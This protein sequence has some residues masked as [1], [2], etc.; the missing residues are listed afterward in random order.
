MSEDNFDQFGDILQK[1]TGIFG[2]DTA[3]MNNALHKH[4]TAQTT[5]LPDG[6]H[7][8]FECPDCGSSREINAEWPEVVCLSMNVSPHQVIDGMTAWAFTAQG[9]CPVAIRC[10]GCTQN[11]L[12]IYITQQ[13]AAGHVKTGE[14][15]GL[16]YFRPRQGPNGQRAPSFYQTLATHIRARLQQPR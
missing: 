1:E 2:L 14:S 10:S 12:R 9:W 16:P 13:E 4:D 6:V 5:V 11:D 7:T 15:Q 3:S 8:T